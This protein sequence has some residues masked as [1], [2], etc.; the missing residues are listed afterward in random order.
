MILAVNSILL[1]T[2]IHKDN[3]DTIILILII[4]LLSG[5]AHLA[6]PIIIIITP[7]M[8]THNNRINKNL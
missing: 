1:I 4:S 8:F 3:I 7:A 6:L 2:Y 5:K